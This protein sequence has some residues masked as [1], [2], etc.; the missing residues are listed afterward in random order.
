MRVLKLSISLVFHCASKV[1]D[2]ARRVVGLPRPSV[3][4]ILYY[5]GVPSRSESRF[6]RQLDELLRSAEPVPLGFEGEGRRGERYVS[7]TFDDGFESVFANA[8]PALRE[9]EVPATVFLPVGCLGAAPSWIADP[10]PEEGNERVVDRDFLEKFQDPLVTFGSH[11]TTHCRL[12]AL[13]GPRKREEIEGSKKSLESL[14]GAEVRFLAFP[15]G[16][17]DAEVLQWVEAAGY[18]AAFS[19]LPTLRPIEKGQLLVG[20]TS[21]STDDWML[22]VRLKAAG[23]YRW[24]GL[25]SRIKRAL[26]PGARK[27]PGNSLASDARDEGDRAEPG[28]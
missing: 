18:R 4:S 6:R 14:L 26:R 8:V 23:A 17:Y 28:S 11:G 16:A 13:D 2:A 24:L 10:S 21:V 15:Y 3:Y 20:R 12:P 9:R 7:V 19:G 27:H 22:E 1:L 25:A 5:H